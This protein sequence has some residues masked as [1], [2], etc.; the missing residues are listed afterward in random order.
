MNRSIL[1]RISA[2]GALAFAALAGCDATAGPEPRGME[3]VHGIA[4]ADAGLDGLAPYVLPDGVS[5]TAVFAGGCF[6]CTE[7]SFEHVPGVLDA[8]S[9]Y[10]G[11]S[12]QNPT[13]AAVGG[14]RTSHLEAIEVR[15]DP[16][17]VSYGELV[18]V[19]WQMV[20]PTD[21]GGQFVDR[22]HQYSSAVFVQSAEQRAV[23]EASRMRLGMSGVLDGPIVTPIR[24]APVFWVAEAYHQD[25][26]RTNPAH[27]M[28]YRK[29]SGRDQ[30]VRQVYG[31]ELHQYPTAFDAKT[32]AAFVEENAVQVGG[33][34]KA[35]VPGLP[36]LDPAKFTKP[37]GAEL[38]KALTPIQFK[39]TQRDGTEPPFNNPYWDN[40]KAGLYVDVVTGEPLFSSEHKFESGTGWPSFTQPL[41]PVREIVDSALGMVRTEVRSPVGDSH[42]GHVFP[43]GPPPTGLRYCINSA[44]LRFIAVQDLEAEGYGDYRQHFEG[45]ASAH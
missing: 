6:W 5:A 12:E 13:Y 37:K 23:A 9:G 38:G 3:V 42:L 44:S 33:P 22:G 15:Y 25:Y 45:I 34:T 4:A 17:V 24:D 19:F 18:E 26:H 16:K 36:V 7:S 43:D 30:H 31:P 28:R 8:V 10:S 20:D 14:H 2:A 40:H 32:A 39:V 11:G 27:Y 1:L 35:T 29:G 21:A 41:Y